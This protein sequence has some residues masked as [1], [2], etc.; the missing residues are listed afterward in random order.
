MTPSQSPISPKV[1]L[2]GLLWALAHASVPAGWL[3]FEAL[4]AGK[5]IQW[6]IEWHVASVSALMGVAGYWRKYAALV[7]L[8]PSL[9]E[10]KALQGSAQA[11]QENKS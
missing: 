2:L 8:P 10:A 7:T 6:S 1:F 3:L 9:L 4:R 5:P 11:A